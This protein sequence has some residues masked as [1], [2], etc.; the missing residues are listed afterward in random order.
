MRSKTKKR[1]IALTLAMSFIF[2]LMFPILAFADVKSGPN[3]EYCTITHVNR[4]YNAWNSTKENPMQGFLAITGTDLLGNTGGLP[5]TIQFSEGCKSY[6][7]IVQEIDSTGKYTDKFNLIPY[8]ATNTTSQ[9]SVDVLLPSSWFVQGI[10]YRIY[11]SGDFD[12]LR[13]QSNVESTAF[14]HMVRYRD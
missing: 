1:S 10:T 14:V 6:C 8:T 3:N 7:I 9:N 13:G 11:C 5:I 4:I 2:S 12:H